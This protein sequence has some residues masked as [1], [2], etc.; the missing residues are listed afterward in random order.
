MVC[1]IAIDKTF[2][3]ASIKQRYYVS[4]FWYWYLSG[5]PRG[6]KADIDKNAW[7]IPVSALGLEN[8]HST[9]FM[10]QYCMPRTPES[11]LGAPQLG[12]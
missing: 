5:T 12:G 7:P 3:C 2:L 6:I 9:V 10:H 1:E 11:Q 4:I 8:P